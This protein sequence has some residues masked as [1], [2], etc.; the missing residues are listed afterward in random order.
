MSRR[1]CGRGANAVDLTRWLV[2]QASSLL[3]DRGLSRQDARGTALSQQHWEG[4][5]PGSSVAEAEGTSFTPEPQPTDPAEGLLLQ[6]LPPT[7]LFETLAVPD[8][9]RHWSMKTPGRSAWEVYSSKG[10]QRSMP[11]VETSPDADDS[12]GYAA[13]SRSVDVS[14][15]GPIDNAHLVSTWPREPPVLCAPP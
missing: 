15:S 10:T 9:K 3:Y 14:R 12:R 2:A 6:G 13:T 8:W 1:W 11:T 4:A 5:P 7:H